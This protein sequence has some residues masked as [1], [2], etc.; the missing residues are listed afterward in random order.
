MVKTAEGQE[1]ECRII[2]VGV[3]SWK[4]MEEGMD[5]PPMEEGS[6]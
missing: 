5:Y 4:P 2:W 3:G 6:P 1:N